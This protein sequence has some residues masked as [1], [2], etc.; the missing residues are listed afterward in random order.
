MIDTVAIPFAGLFEVT[1]T[2]M[3]ERSTVLRLCGS[4]WSAHAEAPLP[5]PPRAGAAEPWRQA[6][7]WPLEPSTWMVWVSV[8]VLPPRSVTVSVTV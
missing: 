5:E 7:G 6:R 3:P 4:S 2:A 1:R 8:A